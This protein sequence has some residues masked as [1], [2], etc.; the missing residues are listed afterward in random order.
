VEFTATGDVH[1]RPSA[2]DVPK[3]E[4]HYVLWNA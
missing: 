2:Y 1:V 3:H 4:V